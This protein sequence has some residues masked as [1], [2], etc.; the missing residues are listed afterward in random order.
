MDLTVGS[1][2]EVEADGD[3]WN[4]TVVGL[5]TE[6]V[7]VHFDGGEASPLFSACRAE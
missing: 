7:Q 5:T 2:I 3:W 4:A 6:E 1:R